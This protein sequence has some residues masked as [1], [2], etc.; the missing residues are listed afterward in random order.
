MVGRLFLVDA[1]VSDLSPFS[2]MMKMMRLRDQQ[3]RTRK[4]KTTTMVMM[5][6]AIRGFVPTPSFEAFSPGLSQTDDPLPM[7]LC[8]SLYLSPRLGVVGSVH[9]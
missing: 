5:E 7:T 6:R 9:F 3:L 8:D 2:S 4:R 1:T